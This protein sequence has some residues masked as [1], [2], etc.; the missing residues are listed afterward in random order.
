MRSLADSARGAESLGSSRLPAKSEKHPPEQLLSQMIETA[1]QVAN[2]PLP[3]GQ[4]LAAGQRREVERTRRVG[5][6]SETT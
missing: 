5:A 6:H 4:P 1:V 3:P 2:S